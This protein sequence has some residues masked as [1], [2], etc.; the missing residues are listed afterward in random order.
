[1]VDSIANRVMSSDPTKNQN[2]YLGMP[3]KSPYGHL[4]PG[5][6]DKVNDALDALASGSNGKATVTAIG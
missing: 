4:L 2:L 5:S 1:V 3:I 6:E